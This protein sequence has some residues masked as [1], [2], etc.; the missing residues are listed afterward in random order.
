MCYQGNDYVW[1]IS[2]STANNTRNVQLVGWLVVVVV[3]VFH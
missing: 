3:V 2:F 1:T